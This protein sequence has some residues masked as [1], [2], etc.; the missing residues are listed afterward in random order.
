MAFREQLSSAVILG[1]KMVEHEI[2]LTWDLSHIEHVNNTRI[3]SVSIPH[4]SPSIMHSF[5]DYRHK[6]SIKTIFYSLESIF[7][8]DS[9]G[10]S[11]ATLT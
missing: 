7:V 2:C 6:S 8:A 11:S 10:L 4:R 9:I 5:C 3:A 1:P